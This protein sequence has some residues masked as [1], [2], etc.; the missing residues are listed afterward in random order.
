MVAPWYVYIVKC[1]DDTLYTGSTTNV[2]ARLVAHNSLRAGARYTRAR[3][4]V[5]LVYESQWP[6][7]TLAAKEEWRIKQ[8]TRSAKLALCHAYRDRLHD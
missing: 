6:D 4:P 8:L 7:R 3:Q 2:K 1:A 5:T